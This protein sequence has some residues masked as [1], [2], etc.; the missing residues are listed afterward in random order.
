MRASEMPIFFYSTL[1]EG[2]GG[3]VVSSWGQRV[4]GS[5]PYSTKDPPCMRTRCKLNLTS[6]DKRPPSGVV[7]KSGERMPSQVSSSPSDWGSKL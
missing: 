4:P 1:L 7:R 2:R 3:L 6:W 5:K